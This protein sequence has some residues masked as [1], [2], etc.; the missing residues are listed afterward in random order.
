MSDPAAPAQRHSRFWLFAPFVL[1][2]VLALGWTIAWFVIR[3]RTGAGIDAW[4]AQEAAH[5]RLWECP[6]RSIGG[7]PFRIE[8]SCPRI[9]MTRGEVTASA[10][11]LTSVTQ[12]YQPRH[13]IVEIAGPLRVSDG[14]TTLDASWKALQASVRSDGAG[15]QAAALVIGAPSLRIAGLTPTE[16]MASAQSFEAHLRP[17]PARPASEAVYD[18]ASSTSQ[19]AIPL[20]D[21]F[22]GGSEPTDGALEL[23][24]T[25]A[26]EPGPRPPTEALERWRQAGG[27]LA[28]GRLS[29][30][31]GERRIEAKGELALDELRRPAGRLDVSAAGLADLLATVTGGRAGGLAGGLLG[32]LAGN[33][34]GGIAPKPRIEQPAAGEPQGRGKPALAPLPPVIIQNGK[35]SLGPFV[36]PGVR[37]M[38]LY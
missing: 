27:R 13:T 14:R 32:G 34:L 18:I 9:A 21:G 17:D 2:I 38:P 30:S 36:V 25:Q 23:A 6:G 12:V 35:I 1:L 26:R 10:A 3:E 20:L 11:G 7:F 8:V 4:M 29:L 5:G 22:I 31:K 15:L 28:I 24:V 33:L 16:V 19:A 37:L